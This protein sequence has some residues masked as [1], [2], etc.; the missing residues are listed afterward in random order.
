MQILF[1]LCSASYTEKIN[2]F[3]LKLTNVILS[4]YLLMLSLMPATLSKA[5][6]TEAKEKHLESSEM[7]KK[8]QFGTFHR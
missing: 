8:H 6:G 3:I 4:K 7:L 5:A 1:N 2:Y